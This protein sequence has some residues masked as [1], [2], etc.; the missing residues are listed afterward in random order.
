VLGPPLRVFD[1]ERVRILTFTSLYPSSVRPRHG[2]FIQERI[3]Q[4]AR[5]TGHTVQ[6]VAPVPYFPPLR[7][8]HRWELTQ[9]PRLERLSGLEVHHPRYFMT[10]KV[11]MFS[12]GWLMYRGTRR[13][14]TELHRRAPFDLIDAHYVFPDGYAALRIGKDLGLPVV[15]S[16]RGTDIHTYPR[17]R[18][19]RGILRRCLTQADRLIAVSAALKRQMCELG[20]AADRVDVIPN[21]VDALK[22]HPWCRTAARERLGVPSGPVLL[23]AGNLTRN[24][25]F[26]ILIR[27]M[28]E[29]RRSFPGISLVIL[30]EGPAR[31]EL[32]ALIQRL[33]LQGVAML[34]GAQD[35]ATLPLWYSAAD[36]FC[37]AS[38]QEGCP[39][40]ILESISC[41]TPVVA[42]R[43]GGIPE[44]VDSGSVGILAERTTPDFIRAIS[45]GLG[46]VWDRASI[47]GTASARGWDRVSEALVRTFD[48]ALQSRNEARR[49][50]D[51]AG[52]GRRR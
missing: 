27:A 20:A 21:G 29:L 8:T 16:A 9:V 18:S 41:G 32:E 39:N 36:L 44:I 30:G 3:S 1:A 48:A 40:V 11:G 49:G 19:I 51:A 6:V 7:W 14:V 17:L 23:S 46:R 28:Q 25:G 52:G 13:L 47:A 43:A 24:K 37:L 34:R 5:H 42:S 45:L 38:A 12:Y 33:E 2:V 50:R 4:L 22:F 31:G 15:L 26:D 10:P 35:Q